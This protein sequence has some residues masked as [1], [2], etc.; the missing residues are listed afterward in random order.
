MIINLI[1]FSN[2][3]KSVYHK[4]FSGDIIN[5]IE[6]NRTIIPFTVLNDKKN[7]MDNRRF[8][9]DLK[10]LISSR[11]END[12]ELFA[13]TV[14][15]TPEQLHLFLLEKGDP[16][17]AICGELEKNKEPKKC[18]NIQI[19]DKVIEINNSG[20]GM[21]NNFEGILKGSQLDL[22]KSI[23]EENS[24]LHKL[25]KGKDE[26]LKDKDELLSEKDKLISALQETIELLKNK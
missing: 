24:T 23:K 1:D 18:G 4:E 8:I 25:I 11:F 16:P 2:N 9:E 7:I 12:I 17:K 3:I 10:L 26:L 5:S 21:T 22:I 14:G 6:G 15:V 20:D 19:G 13:R